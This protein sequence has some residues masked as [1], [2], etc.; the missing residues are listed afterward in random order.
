MLDPTWDGVVVV[1]VRSV[2]LWHDTQALPELA[3]KANQGFDCASMSTVHND[4][5]PQLGCVGWVD[6]RANSSLWV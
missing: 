2:P 3:G 6:G 5:I 4:L 1:V